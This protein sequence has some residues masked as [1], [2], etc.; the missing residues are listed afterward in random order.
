MNKGIFLLALFFFV[1]LCFAEA[2]DYYYKSADE[3]EES[4]T[5]PVDTTQKAKKWPRMSLFLH[6]G[7][8]DAGIGTKIRV[9]HEN[10][11]YLTIDAR[12]QKSL[13]FQEEYI[14]IPMLCYI[15]GNHV[16]FITGGT[17]LNYVRGNMSISIL[18]LYGS[19]IANGINVDIGRHFGIDLILFTPTVWPSETSHALLLAGRLTF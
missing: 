7:L 12:Y 10:R 15:G 11:I 13:I 1:A 3:S 5:P 9:A 2:P 19:E 14:R 18:G 4:S 17:F 6:A 16:H 8:I